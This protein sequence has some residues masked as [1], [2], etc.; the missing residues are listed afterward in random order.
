MSVE[1]WTDETIDKF[2]AT[3]ATAI[4][5]NS[6]GIASI[7]EVIREATA[8]SNERMSRIDEQLEDLT[9][10]TQAIGRDVAQLVATQQA[11]EQERA[12]LRQATL[13]IANLL[14][15]LDSDRPTILRK[16]NAIENKVDRL[17]EQ[18]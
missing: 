3:A 4:A 5:A 16:L 10:V 8:V 11:A 14:A 6:E 18:Q 7:R 1:R 17:L 9:A 2:A 13:G 15:S 12:E